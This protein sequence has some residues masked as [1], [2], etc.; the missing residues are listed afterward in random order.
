MAKALANRIGRTLVPGG[1]IR[2]L[3]GSQDID[4]GR[5]EGAEMIRILNMP[6]QRGRV[7]LR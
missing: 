3:L 5:A 6:V 1:V 2:C 4:K 7:E